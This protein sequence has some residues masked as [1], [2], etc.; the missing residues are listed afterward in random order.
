MSSN[1]LPDIARSKSPCTSKELVSLKSG[2]L[3]KVLY[4]FNKLVKVPDLFKTRRYFKSKLISQVCPPSMVPLFIFA[5]RWWETT[6]VSEICQLTKSV[7]N[8]KTKGATNWI[9]MCFAI[10]KVTSLLS[11]KSN[12]KVTFLNSSRRWIY[13]L[14]NPWHSVIVY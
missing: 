5:W 13:V 7:R 8:T 1:R 12:S 14:S 2:S 9:T 10:Q 11:I 4:P 6:R 3:V